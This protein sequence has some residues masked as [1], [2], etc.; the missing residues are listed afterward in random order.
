VVVVGTVVTASADPLAPHGY[1]NAALTARHGSSKVA[2][3]CEAAAEEVNVD[4]TVVTAPADPLAPRGP[5][6]A[7]S[8]CNAPTVEMAVAG[9]TLSVSADAPAPHSLATN[10]HEELLSQK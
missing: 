10:P 1:A 7:A 5:T 2:P 8:R 6:C 4:G 9:M 3:Q